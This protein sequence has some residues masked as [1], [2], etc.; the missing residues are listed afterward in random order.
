MI[1]SPSADLPWII[2][3]SEVPAGS[4]M[5]I[6]SDANLVVTSRHVLVT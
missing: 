4:G 3:F 2:R 1:R 5:I 6:L